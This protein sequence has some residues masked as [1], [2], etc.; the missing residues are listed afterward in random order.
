[1]QVGKNKKVII[2]RTIIKNSL[3]DFCSKDDKKRILITDWWGTEDFKLVCA[4]AEIDEDTLANIFI[5]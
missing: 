4:D 2:N 3:N 1:M 5:R